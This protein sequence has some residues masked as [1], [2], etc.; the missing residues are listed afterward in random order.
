MAGSSCAGTILP[1]GPPQLHHAA[2]LHH[3]APL[4]F[5]FEA[6]RQRVRA[7]PVHRAPRRPRRHAF[8]RQNLQETMAFPSKNEGFLQLFPGRNDLDL[9]MSY[10]SMTCIVFLDFLNLSGQTDSC[11]C[12]IVVSKHSHSSKATPSNRSRNI[13]ISVSNSYIDI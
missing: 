8:E 2:T 1:T 4:L 11:R 9:F 10:E 12:L 5:H 7:G 6:L 3:L 13:Q